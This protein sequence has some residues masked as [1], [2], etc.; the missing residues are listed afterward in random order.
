MFATVKEF[1]NIIGQP[2][3][4]YRQEYKALEKLRQAFFDKVQNTPDVEKYIE[5]YK[6]FDSSVNRM[7]QQLIPASMWQIGGVG[8][9]IESHVFERNKYWNKYPTFESKF[10]VIEGQMLGINE[11]LYDYECGSPP[12]SKLHTP[13]PFAI[14]ATLAGVLDTTSLTDYNAVDVR[15]PGSAGGLDRIIRL[16]MVP[17]SGF[18]SICSGCPNGRVIWVAQ[19]A[20]NDATT[21]TRIKAAIN[22]AGDADYDANYM[23]YSDYH[24]Y[25]KSFL[26]S[27]TYT[28]TI[29]ALD[30][31]LGVPGVTAATSTNLINLTANKQGLAG[32]GIWVRNI[33]RYSAV[34]PSSQFTPSESILVKD[35]EISSTAELF[36]RIHLAGGA[37]PGTDG[38]DAPEATSCLWWQE[39]A[40]RNDILASPNPDVNTDKE[41]IRTVLTTKI[42]VKPSTHA[43]ENGTKYQ[44]S[45][46]VKRNLSKPYKFGVVRN[47]IIHG[48]PNSDDDQRR[49]DYVAPVARSFGD[50]NNYI[51]FT[52]DI[53]SSASY[54]DCDDPAPEKKRL[55][56]TVLR[57]QNGVNIA[58]ESGKADLFA[59]FTFYSSSARSGWKDSAAAA[60]AIPA[61]SSL[62]IN[63]KGSLI[64]LR[65]KTTMFKKKIGIS[66]MK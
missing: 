40:P 27:Y 3:N 12:V 58:Y 38:R 25:E 49:I 35:P 34:S 36:K 53:P 5:F 52:T 31:A 28:V 59:P 14:A 39:Q 60:G 23:T 18:G 62:D 17:E 63:T 10:P 4:R 37:D 61:E 15:V 43:L 48:G 51:E 11:M 24:T 47:K 26:G 8:D 64:S 13:G 16:V 30:P 22:G 33:K 66:A 2:V 54:C 9:T 56:N 45:T 20:S 32:N 7:L 21:A 42:S 55:V 50:N 6:W 44:G 57:Y 19:H 29:P 46:Y 41:A 1:N 65:R